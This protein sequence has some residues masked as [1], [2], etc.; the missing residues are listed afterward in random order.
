VF[1]ILSEGK[2]GHP[3]ME[4]PDWACAVPMAT[5]PTKNIQDA[6]KKAKKHL[7]FTH[8]FPSLVGTN[9]FPPYRKSR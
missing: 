3:A 1:Q 6:N 2:M 8:S 5:P 7:M 9:L 4:G